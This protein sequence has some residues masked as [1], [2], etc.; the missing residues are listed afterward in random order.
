MTL[1]KAINEIE[2]EEKL[3]HYG[4]FRN[5]NTQIVDALHSVA[6]ELELLRITIEKLLDNSKE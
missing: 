6:A 5:Q 2:S 1:S 4:E 3:C